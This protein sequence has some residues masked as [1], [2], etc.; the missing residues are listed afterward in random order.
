MREEIKTK[1]KVEISRENKTKGKERSLGKGLR[2]D[3]IKTK[4]N[5]MRVNSEKSNFHNANIN[6]SLFF[7]K[8]WRRNADSASSEFNSKRI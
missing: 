6:C 2:L 3:P 5:E 1:L 7:C 8:I 4:I